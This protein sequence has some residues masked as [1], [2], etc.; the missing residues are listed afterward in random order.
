LS[1]VTAGNG[2]AAE[3]FFTLTFFAQR[4]SCL[5]KSGGKEF[6]NKSEA[7]NSKSTYAN[8][9]MDPCLLLA[10]AGR[11]ETN[12]KYQSTKFQTKTE[13]RRQSTEDRGQVSSLV[14]RAPCLENARHRRLRISDCRL[15]IQNIDGVEGLMYCVVRK[16]PL[17]ALI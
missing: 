14:T 6:Q 4:K 16:K 8:A 11:S 1:D 17:E 2:F 10:G 7:R 9:T 12:P 3:K 5:W 13:D 15:Q